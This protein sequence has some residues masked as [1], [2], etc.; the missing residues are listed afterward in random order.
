MGKQEVQEK[1]EHPPLWGPCVEDQCIGGVF[2]Y[3][4]HMG[5]TCQE[6]QDPLQYGPRIPGWIHLMYTILPCTE[7]SKLRPVN[8]QH[9]SLLNAANKSSWLWQMAGDIV[10]V[11][12][13]QNCCYLADTV[14]GLG[15]LSVGVGTTN[16]PRF[17][18]QHFLWKW[19][20]DKLL[21]WLASLHQCDLI[22][23][24]MPEYQTNA[25]GFCGKCQQLVFCMKWHYYYK[26]YINKIIIITRLSNNLADNSPSLSLLQPSLPSLRL[27][28]S[29]DLCLS[30][31]VEKII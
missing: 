15:L 25:V 16:L 8:I 30:L 19:S 3:L 10:T 12:L 27:L 5:A 20:I 14:L 4:H 6:A 17:R 31:S 23:E 7:T 22:I 9:V 29:A 21:R 1:A 13:P 26:H 28:I 24:R 2:A 11:T 18:S